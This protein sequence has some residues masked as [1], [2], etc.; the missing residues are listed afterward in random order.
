MSDIWR[1]EGCEN[2]N[3]GSGSTCLR[4]GSARAASSRVRV[5][6]EVYLGPDEW[7]ILRTA[8]LATFF[9]VSGV[10]RN[11][12]EG[13]RKAMIAT[14]AGAQLFDSFLLREACGRL[15][16]ELDEADLERE[17]DEREEEF[18]DAMRQVARVLDRR[19]DEEEAGAFRRGLIDLARIV[20][21]ATGGGVFGGANRVSEVETGAIEA[22]G[23]A[24]GHREGVQA[25]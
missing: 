23:D 21:G 10:D 2:R 3:P 9:Y 8:P 4:C 1:C 25:T 7:K 17:P 6:R 15:A 5:G 20:A 13:E 16:R 19:L 11:L 24:L 18:E 14:L 12:D 22:I